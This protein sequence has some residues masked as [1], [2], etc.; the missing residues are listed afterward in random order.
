MDAASLVAVEVT[1]NGYVFQENE[2]VTVGFL[3]M[4]IEFDGC[5]DMLVS[6]GVA[7]DLKESADGY[8]V[9]S[10]IYAYEK[11]EYYQEMPAN[12]STI[13]FCFNGGNF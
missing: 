3:E 1:N 10:W 2:D 8:T 11:E 7:A 5:D 12:C 9:G 4:G 13:V 6:D